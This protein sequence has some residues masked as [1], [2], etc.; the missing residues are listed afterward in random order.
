[1]P[2]SLTPLKIKGK[3][4]VLNTGEAVNPQQVATPSYLICFRASASMFPPTVSITPENL[5]L[6]M[7]FLFSISKSFLNTTS[8]A[9]IAFK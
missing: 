8:L 9:P 6:P 3:T 2:I 4:L 1:M 7:G 5:S